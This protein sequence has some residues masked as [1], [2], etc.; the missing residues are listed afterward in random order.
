MRVFL[1]STYFFPLIGLAVKSV[2]RDVVAFL[3]SLEDVE[4]LCSTIT[5]FEL[6]AK[7]ARLVQSGVLSESDVVEGVL[8]LQH[9]RETAVRHPWTGEVQRLAMYFRKGHPD[10]VDCLILA[11]AV[12]HAERFI[13]ED[14]TIQELV[15]RSWMKAISDINNDFAVLSSREAMRLPLGKDRDK[16]ANKG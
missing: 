2:E 14:M 15:Q 8:A 11:S 16:N 5:L 7:G 3:L 6:S 13:S 12:V 4:L 9:S 10:Y 1:D